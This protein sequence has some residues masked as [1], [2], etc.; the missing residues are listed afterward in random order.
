MEQKTEIE[1]PHCEYAGEIFRSPEKREGGVLGEGNSQKEAPRDM[2]GSCISHF[3]RDYFRIGES[4]EN[5]A[6]WD[7][8]GT[9]EREIYKGN[10]N[11]TLSKVRVRYIL[12]EDGIY[13]HFLSHGSNRLGRSP[14]TDTTVHL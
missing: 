2:D 14:V 5:G 9:R 11:G 6:L 1:D 8:I 10:A 12:R 3:V 13:K 4:E 7:T